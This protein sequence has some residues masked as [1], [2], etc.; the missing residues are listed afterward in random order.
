M[1]GAR[2]EVA[3][4]Q[5]ALM[6]TDTELNVARDEAIDASRQLKAV[7]GERVAK[8][9]QVRRIT[10]ARR[11]SPTA[12]FFSPFPASSSRLV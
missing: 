9:S 11:L 12:A 10:A 3:A 7:L 5:A 2:F 6:E 4:A 1:S 8:E